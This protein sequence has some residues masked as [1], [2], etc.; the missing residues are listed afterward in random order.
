ME[1]KLN[2]VY[3][4]TP[5]DFRSKQYPDA[6]VC[7]RFC[8]QNKEWRKVEKCVDFALPTKRLVHMTGLDLS[9]QTNTLINQDNGR[10]QTIMRDI[11]STH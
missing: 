4:S 10:C 7:I 11:Y 9:V 1:Q 3:Y 8:Y 5:T 2:K 6:Q